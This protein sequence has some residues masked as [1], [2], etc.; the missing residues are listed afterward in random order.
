MGIPTTG[1]GR[2]LWY[3]DVLQ[4][5]EEDLAKQGIEYAQTSLD[6][7]RGDAKSE[8]D[9]IGLPAPTK[10]LTEWWTAGGFGWLVGVLLII[11]GAGLARRQ[12]TADS[13]GD[14]SEG[15]SANV[16]FLESVCGLLRDGLRSSRHPSP[17]LEWTWTRPRLVRKSIRLWPSSCYLLL[18]LVDGMSRDMDSAVFAEYFGLFA[19]GERNLARCWSALTD[20]HSEVARVALVRF[21]RPLGSRRGPGKGGRQSRLALGADQGA[22]RGLA[23]V[24]SP[25]NSGIPERGAAFEHDGTGLVWYLRKE[26]SVSL[27]SGARSVARWTGHLIPLGETP[28][29]RMILTFPGPSL[30][31]LWS[32]S[33]RVHASK[34]QEYFPGPS[35]TP[36]GRTRLTEHFPGKSGMVAFPLDTAI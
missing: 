10:R 7:A 2:Q 9:A 34:P 15:G 26:R 25:T 4:S 33:A 21:E 23:V 19:A 16:D 8:Q 31:G 28:G 1:I 14:S 29:A 30:T 11:A 22:S 18:M 32:I 3:A 27:D 36:L 5:E 17:S 20:G 12:A 24:G 35:I 13:V 6:E